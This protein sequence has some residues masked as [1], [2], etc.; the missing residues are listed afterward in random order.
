MALIIQKVIHIEVSCIIEL[1]EIPDTTN[2]NRV[3]ANIVKKIRS[4]PFAVRLRIFNNRR[5]AFAI[6]AINKMPTTSP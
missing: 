5:N 4:F 2:V 3:D 6:A 1:E